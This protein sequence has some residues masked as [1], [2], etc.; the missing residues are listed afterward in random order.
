VLL[1]G[2][3]QA[4]HTSFVLQLQEGHLV[5]LLVGGKCTADEEIYGFTHAGFAQTSVATLVAV[6]AG[7]EETCHV[8][9]FGGVDE[10]DILFEAS[11]NVSLLAVPGEDGAG[12]GVGW[13]GGGKVV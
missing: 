3:Q 5:P 10:V 4:L 11:A 6:V 2:A 12:H 7:V 8:Y 1:E 9:F 13:L